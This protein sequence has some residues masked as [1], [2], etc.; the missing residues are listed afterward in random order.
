MKKISKIVTG[1]AAAA[2]VTTGFAAAPAEAQRYRTY[3]H[4]YYDRDRG[5][6]AGDVIAGVAIIGGIAATAIATIIATP[7]TGA[8]TRP[9]AT[10]AADASA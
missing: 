8:A 6:D 1:A 4:R 2:L 7:S 9:S 10:A 3:D 5:I